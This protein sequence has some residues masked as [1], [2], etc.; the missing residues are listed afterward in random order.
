MSNPPLTTPDLSHISQV[1]VRVRWDRLLSTRLSKPQLRTSR[2]AAAVLRSAAGAP[3][4]RC[5]SSVCRRPDVRQL[6]CSQ[7]KATAT[8]ARWGTPRR[9]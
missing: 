5:L 4:R 9:P 2:L 7:C 6:L 3:T 1:H 8:Y